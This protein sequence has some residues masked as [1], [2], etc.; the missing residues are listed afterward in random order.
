MV[1]TYPDGQLVQESLVYVPLFMFPD[2]FVTGML[3]GAL[4]IYRPD[5]VVTFNDERYIAGK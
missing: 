4:V 1:Q 5:W 3:P 2:A